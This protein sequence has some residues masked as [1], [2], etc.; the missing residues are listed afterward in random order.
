MIMDEPTAALAVAEQ[1]KVLEL[2]R[3]LRDQGV[4]V[5]I[6]SHNLL[7]VFAVADR[8]VV[9]RRA[10]KVAELNAQETDMDEVVALM[11]G[12]KVGDA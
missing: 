7:D 9:L 3:T 4:P 12:S 1:R 10:R 11:T 8:I 6:I 2:C 5:I